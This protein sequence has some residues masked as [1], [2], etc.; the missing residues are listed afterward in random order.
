MPAPTEKGVAAILAA[1]ASPGAEESWR[2]YQGRYGGSRITATDKTAGD[3][4]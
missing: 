3:E 4:S 1:H 2:R